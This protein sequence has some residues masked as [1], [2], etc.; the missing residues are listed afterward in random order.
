M[1]I[2]VGPEFWPRAIIP[3]LRHQLFDRVV[4]VVPAVYLHT[5]ESALCFIFIVTGDWMV[6]AGGGEFCWGEMRPVG[7]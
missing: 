6:E 2:E 1:V 4:Y 5:T 3:M 7:V